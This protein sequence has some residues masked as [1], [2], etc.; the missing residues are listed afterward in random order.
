MEQCITKEP[1]TISCDEVADKAEEY[2]YPEPQERDR[3]PFACDDAQQI[4][5]EKVECGTWFE[6]HV[7][8]RI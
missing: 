7:S 6:L 1:P 5:D 2:K 8:D 4:W 3:G